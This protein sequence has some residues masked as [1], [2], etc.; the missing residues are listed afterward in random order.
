M[1]GARMVKEIAI[2]KCKQFISEKQNKPERRKR[3]L[4]YSGQAQHP[5]NKLIKAGVWALGLGVGV[6]G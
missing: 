1:P 2:L 4:A 6:G 3:T 5:E